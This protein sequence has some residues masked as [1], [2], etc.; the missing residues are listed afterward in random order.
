[1][2]PASKALAHRSSRVFHP[3]RGHGRTLCRQTAAVRIRSGS[4]TARRAEKR[5]MVGKRKNLR[6]RKN[7]RP[8]RL[9]CTVRSVLTVRCSGGAP[10]HEHS[11][12]P[13]RSSPSAPWHAANGHG[14]VQPAVCARP[15][16]Q[17]GSGGLC[18]LRSAAWSPSGGLRW[19]RS[20]QT[21]AVAVQ[22]SARHVPSSSGA[23]AALCRLR[24]CSQRV[25]G[26]RLPKDDSA[27]RPR[28]PHHVTVLLQ[29]RWH[30]RVRLAA[31]Y[32]HR[33]CPAAAAPGAGPAA[34]AC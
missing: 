8:D 20:M 1:M 31:L 13:D 5:S 33:A 3:A 10:P 16:A 29:R 21:R 34:A 6:P 9:C 11:N 28:G 24:T 14:A 7:T 23:S 18:R 17:E 19:Q 2:A 26:N 4:A 27:I 15:C 32:N 12:R 30:V 22:R 25:S